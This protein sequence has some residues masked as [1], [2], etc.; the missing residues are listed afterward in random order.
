M[1]K[2]PLHPLSQR[3]RVKRGGGWGVAAPFTGAPAGVKPAPTI[4][5]QPSA[6]SLICVHFGT[7]L[8]RVVA[9]ATCRELLGTCKTVLNYCRE[10]LNCC[11]KPLRSCRELL[12]TCREL[13]R[14]CKAALKSCRELLGTCRE[15]L[16]SCRALLGTCKTVLNYCRKL[17]RPCREL[18]R[19][20]KALL[21][22]CSRE[23]LGCRRTLL[24]ACR[25]SLYSR[26]R[27][28]NLIGNASRSEAAFGELVYRSRSRLLQELLRRR[29]RG[30]LIWL[31]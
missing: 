31:S 21:K 1:W 12:R 4:S 5:L 24:G 13:L 25:A 19:A 30:I 14:T 17:L 3:G 2:N 10:A 18:L 27:L 9:C 26:Q 8:P 22:S 16:D 28:L 23:V 15:V 7:L 29:A 6:I 11:R 20:C